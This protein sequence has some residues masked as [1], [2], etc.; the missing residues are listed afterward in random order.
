M[1]GP[2]S[3][4]LCRVNLHDHC[5][6]RNQ[7]DSERP[8]CDCSC[9]VSVREPLRHRALVGLAVNGSPGAVQPAPGMAEPA[10]EVR[11]G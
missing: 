10:V 7:L 5:P 8:T 9:H 3:Y 6:G 1:R 2:Y 11:H 4:E